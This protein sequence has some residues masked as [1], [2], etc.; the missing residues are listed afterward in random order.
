MWELLRS[1][2]VLELIVPPEMKVNA[3]LSAAVV[4]GVALAGCEEPDPRPLSQ[5]AAKI[6]CESPLKRLLRDPD[7]YQFKSAAI[8][9][10]TGEFDQYGTATIY[11]RSRNGF[12]GYTD[13]SASCK[14]YEKGGERWWQVEIS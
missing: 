1:R 13:S 9:S 14:A 8:H 6:F 5:S 11:F 3:A 7:S 12:G 4:V 2:M 10:R